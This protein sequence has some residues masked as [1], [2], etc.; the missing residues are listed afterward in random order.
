MK[1]RIQIIKDWLLPLVAGTVTLTIM[2]VV[3]HG[4]DA[5]IGYGVTAV[6]MIGAYQAMQAFHRHRR[7]AKTG[8]VDGHPGSRPVFNA[9]LSSSSRT[10]EA[11]NPH[12]ERHS[13]PADRT[14]LGQ[15]EV[16]RETAT[17]GQVALNGRPTSWAPDSVPGSPARPAY[18]P[19]QLDELA[20]TADAAGLHERAAE[21]RAL[22]AAG[23][24]RRTK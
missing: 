3:L 20:T 23:S 22:Q 24:S 19:A 10:R 21:Y 14:V 16:S 4:N 18:T 2:V 8:V 11:N 1:Q 12:T 15:S 17:E 7:V 9:H 13:A 5:V 6:V